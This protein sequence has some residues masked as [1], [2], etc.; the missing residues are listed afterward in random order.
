MQD[1]HRT[2]PNAMAEAAA[3]IL[4]TFPPVCEYR[5]SCKDSSKRF[6]VV[7][8]AIGEP[9][10][11]V[12]AGDIGTVEGAIQASQKAF[13][14]WRWKTRQERSHY[15]LQAADELQKHSHDLAVLLCLENGKPVK[16]AFFDVGF[17]VQAFRYFGSIVDKLPSESFD[18]GNIYSN[19]I[20][21]PH[22]VCVGIVPFN[23]P[24]V[25]AGGKLAP[26]V[27][28]GNTMVL[29][30]S[31]QAPLTLMRI[32]EILQSV[33]PADVIQAVPGL[34]PEIPQ[35]L[36]SHPFV[37]MVSLTGSTK[38]GSKA[39]QTA[40]A[41]LTP[42]VLELGGKN[43]FVVFEDADLELVVRDTI[44]GA[45]FNKGESCTAASR[46]LVHKDLYPTF[47]G[48]LAAAVEKIRTGDGL[49]ERTHLGP[50]VSRERQQEI[51]SYI[52][53][54]KREGAVLS[55]Q[56]DLPTAGYLSGG[57]YVPPTLFTNVTAEMTIAQEEI[58]GPVVTV[59]AFETEDA[60]TKIVNS[61]Q[62]GLFAGV[63]S[64]DFNRAMRV[65]RKLEVGVV[66]VNNY[67]RALLGTP[68]GG[69][70]SSGYGREHWIGT[71]REWS[72]VKN[73][74]FPSGLG[75][76]PAWDGAIEVCKL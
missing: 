2:T 34:G 25:H 43:A 20:Y 4:K 35:A 50:V 61:S 16:D 28:A 19:V 60:A 53:C 36:I 75:P 51:L 56:G 46:I 68:F 72:R 52:E 63:Y 66:L 49:D 69:V 3:R 74:R 55:A 64:R 58:F 57:F 73:V 40:A 44:D 59:S 22:G 23:W 7:N 71:L 27:A 10:T 11:V 8:P 39:A 13:E 65:A 62:Y 6:T 15:L 42:T 70:K 47:V 30:P 21:E 32:V 18:Q 14:S 33:F 67:F 9:I 76:I 29:K 1:V 31:E 37:R 54:G 12:Q 26:C 45:F 17:L 41:T 38:S 5:W 24:P 48:R